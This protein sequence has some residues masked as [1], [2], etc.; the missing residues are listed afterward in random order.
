MEQEGALGIGPARQ[1]LLHQVVDDVAVVAG[2][3]LHE[4][5]HVGAPAHGEGGQLQ[6]GNP[7]FSACLQCGHIRG[8]EGEPRGLLQKGGGLC[9]GEAQVGGAHVDH[10]A[11][12][13]QAGEGQSWV[14]A[15]GDDEVHVGWEVVE[16]KGDGII[17]GRR[18]D[19]VV[20]VQHEHER[21]GLHG[22]GVDERGE[23]AL[24]GRRLRRGEGARFA[25]A[26]GG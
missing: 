8:G 2:K 22:Q 17:H 20:V 10:L 23:D 4:A 11:A 15:C 7:A 21:I 19:D 9:G 13:A 12:G 6:P 14:L 26:D 24:G 3:G 18:V 5:V 25:L 16:Q 1:H